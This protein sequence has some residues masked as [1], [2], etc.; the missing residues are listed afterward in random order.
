MRRSRLSVPDN[1]GSQFRARSTSPSKRT[2]RNST[3]VRTRSPSPLNV[4]SGRKSIL[5]CSV[6]PYELM[7]T[8]G[9]TKDA[10]SIAI[11]GQKIRIKPETDYEDV[12]IK[13]PASQIPVKTG[14]RRKAK[15]LESET[16]QFRNDTNKFKSILKKP[17]STFNDTENNM[18]VEN[19]I[20]SP[21]FKSGS[22][23][24]LPMPNASRKKVQFL[25][26]NEFTNQLNNDN[27]GEELIKNEEQ[28]FIQQKVKLEELTNGKDDG[29]E[30]PITD[31]E[32]KS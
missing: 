17:S 3:K 11:N 13:K 24:Y 1:T 23:F 27:K 4:T 25:V 19:T 10:S 14:H 15:S 5:E 9:E 22:H 8:N 30:S 7:A 31:D 16:V 18:I 32:G 2:Q 20:K 29:S 6:N 28:D 26:E 12:E 21:G